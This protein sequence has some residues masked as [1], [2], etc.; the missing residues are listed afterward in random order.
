[1]AIKKCVTMRLGV[2][3]DSQ[4]TNA[5][6]EGFLCKPSPTARTAWES[7]MTPSRWNA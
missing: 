1:M 6:L 2:I 5:E 3:Y 4:T 7:Y